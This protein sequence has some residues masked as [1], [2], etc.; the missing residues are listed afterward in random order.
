ME[1]PKLLPPRRI[2]H[3]S[4]AGLCFAFALTMIAII[5]VFVMGIKVGIAWQV[6]VDLR[7][8]TPRSERKQ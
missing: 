2:K 6:A 5:G 4:Y 1:R 7:N 8:E 3:G